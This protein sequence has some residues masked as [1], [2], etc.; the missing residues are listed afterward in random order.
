M[1][2]RRVIPRDFFNEAKLLKCFGQLVIEAE[3]HGDAL[4]IIHRDEGTENSFDIRQN[5]DD[6]SL[7]LASGVAVFLNGRRIDLA[8]SYNSKRAYP[9]FATYRDECEE[10][11]TDEG[12]LTPEFLAMT[13][14]KAA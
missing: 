14:A 4:K 11:F 13:Q 2:Y 9:M 12:K 5:D 3:R 8:T 1:S 6:G 10:V 7:Y